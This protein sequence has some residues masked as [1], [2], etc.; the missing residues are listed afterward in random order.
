MQIS[1]TDI[2]ICQF[3]SNIQSYISDKL[4]HKIY[5]EQRHHKYTGGLAADYWASH[6]I[7]WIQQLR[8]ARDA[9]AFGKWEQ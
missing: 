3:Q 4:F 8:G 7:N 1:T 5:Q 6:G 2:Q 9:Q